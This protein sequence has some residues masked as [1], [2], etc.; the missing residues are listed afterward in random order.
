VR[1]KDCRSDKVVASIIFVG[2]TCK[3][4]YGGMYLPP[5]FSRHN[6]IFFE[7]KYC[8]VATCHNTL[9]FAGMY[10]PPYFSRHNTIF[11]QK[12]LCCDKVATTQY[13]LKKYCVVTNLPQHNIFSKNIVL[14]QLCHNTIFFQ[15]VM[16]CDKV[17]TTQYFLKYCQ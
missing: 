10:L 14:W 16:C 15:K 17:A 1:S 5:Y 3:K 7:K 8:V 6:T 11:F 13:F 12:I 9:F 2:S 4:T